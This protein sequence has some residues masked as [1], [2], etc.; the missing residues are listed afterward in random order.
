MS[1]APEH[2]VAVTSR[3]AARGEMH[4]SC[5][6]GH[7]AGGRFGEHMFITELRRAKTA[8]NAL[9]CPDVMHLP[10]SGERRTEALMEALGLELHAQ[11]H[12]PACL[13]RGSSALLTA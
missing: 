5:S 13:A 2:T 8:S 7:G 3:S 6:T 1:F 11:E 10:S 9:H 4:P 12:M